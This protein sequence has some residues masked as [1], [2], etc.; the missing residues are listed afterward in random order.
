MKTNPLLQPKG[1]WLHLLVAAES[2]VCDRIGALQKSASAMV[3]ARLIRGHKMRT[4]GALFDEFAAALQFPCYFGENWDALNDCLTDLV[5][6][7]GKAYILFIT[8]SHRLL[9]EAGSEERRRFLELLAHI[10]ESWSKPGRMQA[11]H[12]VLQC[13]PEHE[14][15]LRQNLQAAH[16]RYDD[17][18]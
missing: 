9:E 2:E 14:A 11:F 6:L 1:P 7:P 16:V 10:A 3:E 18:K 12:A 4:A 15:K 13:S 8:N 17:L 5:W